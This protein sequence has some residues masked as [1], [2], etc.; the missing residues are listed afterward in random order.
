MKTKSNKVKKVPKPIE[1]NLDTIGLG[2]LIV[3][4]H[5]N[6]KETICSKCTLSVNGDSTRTCPRIHIGRWNTLLCCTFKTG[7]YFIK[8]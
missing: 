8:K 5:K 3:K 6:K 2:T 1:I 7:S 4:T